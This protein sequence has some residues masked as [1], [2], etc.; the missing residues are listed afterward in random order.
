MITTNTLLGNARCRFA[1]ID[2]EGRLGPTCSW[3]LASARL[4]LGHAHLE[5][6]SKGHSGLRKIESSFRRRQRQ[7]GRGKGRQ[8]TRSG[9]VEKMRT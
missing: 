3:E 4:L 9:E 1:S 2:A 7:R 5:A 8:D 6:D